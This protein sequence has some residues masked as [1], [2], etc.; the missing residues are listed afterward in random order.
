MVRSDFPV[1]GVCP[2]LTSTP[3]AIPLRLI[4]DCDFMPHTVVPTFLGVGN[5]PIQGRCV[6]VSAWCGA[7][8]AW[9]A[10]PGMH[11]QMHLPQCLC[12]VS[13]VVGFSPKALPGVCVVDPGVVMSLD[14]PS[15]RCQG[16]WVC[17][18]AGRF[19]SLPGGPWPRPLLL[20]PRLGLLVF[21]GG[22]SQ[23]AASGWGEVLPAEGSSLPCQ[24]GCAWRRI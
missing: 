22:P 23:V 11:F 18:F 2:G 20:S 1:I 3:W 8:Q 6:S 9:A 17:P 14:L 12:Q 7:A 4:L 15:P 21:S 16:S 10:S 24:L 5:T 19:P 13:E